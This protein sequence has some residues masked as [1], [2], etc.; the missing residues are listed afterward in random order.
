[1][2]WFLLL[3]I[4]PALCRAELLSQY[5][6]ARPVPYDLGSWRNVS[7]AARAIHGLVIAPGAEFSFLKSLSPLQREFTLGKS[8]SAGKVVTSIGGGYCQVSAALYNA[9]LLA[10][11][12]ITERHSHSF[13]DAPDAYVEPGRDAA[14][15]GMSGA[16]LRFKND[17]TSAITISVKAIEG[18]VGVELWGTPERKIRRWLVTKARRIPHTVKQRDLGAPRPGFDGFD[19]RRV[20]KEVEA[21]GDTRDT[22]LKDDYYDMIPE[23]VAGTDVQK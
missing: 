16:D 15:S 23:L 18:R 11:L 3:F 13:Y 9:A 12:G 5:S 19:V 22:L 7:V 10:G 8:L 14:V 4:L 1:M 6:C 2:K 17:T 20:L 21:S